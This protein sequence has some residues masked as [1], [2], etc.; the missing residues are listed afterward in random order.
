[1][2][3]VASVVSLSVFTL[4]F[5]AN[6]PSPFLHV[7]RHNNSSPAGAAIIGGTGG[8]I[9]Q[10]FGWGDAKVNVPHWLS[11]TSLAHSKMLT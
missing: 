4:S 7:M 6:R 2:R 5:G 1:M 9:P 11:D 10:H 3:S 8:H